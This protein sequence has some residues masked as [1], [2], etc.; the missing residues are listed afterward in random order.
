MTTGSA[1]IECGPDGLLV[2][3]PEARGASPLALSPIIHADAIFEL[4]PAFDANDQE[5]SLLEREAKG[6]VSGVLNLSDDFDT[7]GVFFSELRLSAEHRLNQPS[8]TDDEIWAIF[9]AANAMDPCNIS[10]VPPFFNQ[11]NGFENYELDMS[12]LDAYIPPA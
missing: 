11:D 2:A 5:A 8:L 1:I 6:S 10:T 7:S 12:S 9:A 3:S 4:N